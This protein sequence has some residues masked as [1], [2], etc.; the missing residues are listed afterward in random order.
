M[1]QTD[2][3]Q[4][5]PHLQTVPGQRQRDAAAVRRAGAGA[6]QHG[7]GAQGGQ[8]A[9]FSRLVAQYD[10]G[11]QSAQIVG[12]VVG[13]RIEVVEQ[14][15]A[16]RWPD[17]RCCRVPAP[18]RRGRRR[19]LGGSAACA[20]QRAEGRLGLVQRF[21]RLGPALAADD[22]ARPGPHADGPAITRTLKTRRADQDIQVQPLA[23]DAA[24]ATGVP[25]PR[26]G[27]QVADHLHDA[28]FG[29]PGDGA[30]GKGGG[31]Q[32]TQRQ[33]GPCSPGH[34]RDQVHHVA[35]AF[36]HHQLRH[37]HRRAGR[38]Q[39]VPDQ[40]EQHDVF[41]AFLGIGAQLGFQRRVFCGRVAAPPGSGDGPGRE[42]AAGAF[43]AHQPLRAAGHHH[44]LAQFGVGH[45]GA[46]V[47]GAQPQ[48]RRQRV[49][50][51]RRADTP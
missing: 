34:F 1:A 38:A 31:Q 17:P 50:R 7:A 3:Q 23:A 41:G 13:E 20:T 26:C 27:L 9:Q 40:I 14:Q 4:R 5:Q 8:V 12:Q 37:P 32:L 6:D 46:G 22:D 19:G 45:K 28:P 10:L 43:P 49:A 47:E 24:Q 35:V 48:I 44:F 15:H 21:A 39:V 16:Q 30:A 11:A 33:I 25:A 2:A 36:D 29:C 42:Q 51:R 18:A